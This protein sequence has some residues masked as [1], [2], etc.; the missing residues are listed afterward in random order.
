MT[1]GRPR[2]STHDL[3]A[4]QVDLAQRP[5]VDDRV[6]RLLRSVSWLLAAKCFGER[7]DALRLDAADQAPRPVAR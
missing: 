2:L 5:L 6:D 4:A 7:P 3:E 1:V